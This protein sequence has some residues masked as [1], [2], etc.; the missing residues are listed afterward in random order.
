MVGHELTGVVELAFTIPFFIESGLEELGCM[1]G[2]SL[3]AETETYVV[4][5]GIDKNNIIRYIGITGRDA[6]IRFGEHYS[7][8]TARS[9]LRYD[10]IPIILIY[11][12]LMHEF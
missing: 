2:A 7:S 9:L 5:Q 8:E 3:E 6:E 10:V 12:G 4:Y 1:E 11:L